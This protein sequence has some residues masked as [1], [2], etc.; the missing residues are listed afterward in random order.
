MQTHMIRLESYAQI[1]EQAHITGV[2]LIP[3]ISRNNNLYTKEELKRFNNVTVPL[4]WEHDPDKQIGKVTFHYNPELETVY[5]D[6]MITDEASAD[7][8]RNKTLFTSIEADP[9]DMKEICNAPNDCFHMPF[10]LVPKALA[11]TETPGV[12]ET[13]VVVIEN[14]I[15]ECQI[16]HE[17]EAKYAPHQVEDK[18]QGEC[19]EGQHMVDGK[20]VVV[21][22]KEKDCNQIDVN[23]HRCIPEIFKRLDFIEHD[24]GLCPDCGEKKKKILL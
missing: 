2:A 13:S 21:S 11:L 10:G 22:H 5:Y 17:L 18:H 14:Y 4:N 8:A 12:P 16:D 9:Q 20:C 15:R 7:L 19:P 1:D 3:R 6:G 23:L 24:L